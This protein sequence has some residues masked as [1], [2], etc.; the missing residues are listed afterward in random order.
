M[1]FTLCTSQAILILAG[2]A[3][4][5]LAIDSTA[6]KFLPAISDMIE[7]EVVA[8]TQYDWLSNIASLKNSFAIS[9]VVAAGC[10]MHAV[11]YD[12]SGYIGDEADKKLDLLA[13]RYLTGLIR[14]SDKDLQK[15]MIDGSPT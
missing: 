5:S 11:D 3:A 12:K 9:H 8:Y 7:G 15:F 13:D 10:A 6:G 2:T 14:L 4:N 1:A